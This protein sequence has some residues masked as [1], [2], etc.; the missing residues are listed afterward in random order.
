MR[1]GI[2]EDI[3]KMGEFVFNSNELSNLGFLYRFSR[4]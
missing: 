1:I 3:L 2:E 4:R